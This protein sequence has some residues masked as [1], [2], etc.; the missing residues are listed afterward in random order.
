M[1][2]LYEIIQ[3]H[4]HRRQ[5][6]TSIQSN[7]RVQPG[8]SLEVETQRGLDSLHNEWLTGRPEIEWGSTMDNSKELVT[9]EHALKQIVNVKGN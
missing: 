3:N 4:P 1:R 6:R 9:V 7:E 8:V 2:K 5:L